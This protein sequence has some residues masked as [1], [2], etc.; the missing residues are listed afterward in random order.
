MGRRMRPIDPTA[1]PVERFAS[2]LRALRAISGDLPFWKM[3]RR[4]EVSK[5][6]L[7]AAVAGQQL[8]SE[9]VVREFVRACG[10]EWAPWR[11]RWLRTAAEVSALAED[12]P[13]E[14]V[15][16]VGAELT[17]VRSRLPLPLDVGGLGALSRLD[18]GVLAE[19]LHPLAQGRGRR[20]RRS[21]TALVALVALA[22][23][24]AGGWQVGQWRR[25][26]Q[27]APATRGVA[28]GQDPYHH[29]CGADEI[30]LERRP[31]Y[32]ADGTHYGT[33]ILYSSITCL[34]A[35]GYVVGPNSP[36]WT[37]HIAAHRAP[38]NVEA[39]SSYRGDE[40]PNSWGNVLSDSHGCVRAEAWIDNGPHAMTSCWS[41]SGPVTHLP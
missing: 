12:A 26:P 23:V 31:I 40:R 6:A 18:E 7:A 32:R 21:L 38:D 19:P 33:L 37:V 28:D 15:P 3:A 14:D 24:F 8:P 36:Q 5:S 29:N 17:P 20:R 30:S 34:A 41:P 22:G 13:A 4:C 39:V 2:E 11:E 9:R 25:P 1:G 10:A 16:A 27:P 35:W